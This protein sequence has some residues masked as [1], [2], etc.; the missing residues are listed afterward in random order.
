[1]YCFLWFK[2]GGLQGLGYFRVQGCPGRFV[3]GLGIL[4]GPE[5][6]LARSS[7][8]RDLQVCFGSGFRLENCRGFRGLGLSSVE[9][10]GSRDT[11]SFLLCC[12]LRE[13]GREAWAAG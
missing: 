1:M 12:L 7:K 9:C 4:A 3:S 8:G 2:L 13:G 10:W 6:A 11:C 5:S